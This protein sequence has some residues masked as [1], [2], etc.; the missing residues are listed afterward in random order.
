[1]L[2]T[3]GDVAGPRS[4]SVWWSRKINGYWGWGVVFCTIVT[5]YNVLWWCFV[6]GVVFSDLEEFG[7]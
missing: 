1:M 6:T 2:V 3:D 4:E 7:E 5:G